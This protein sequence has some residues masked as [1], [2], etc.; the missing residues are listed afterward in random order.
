MALCCSALD[1]LKRLV[2]VGYKRGRHSKNGDP[3]LRRLSDFQIGFL[4]IEKVRDALIINFNVGASDKKFLFG[5][6]Q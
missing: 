3:S 6:L 5:T 1:D 4:R 2:R